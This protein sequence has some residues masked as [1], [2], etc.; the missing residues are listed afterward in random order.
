VLTVAHEEADR[1]DERDVER[2]TSLARSSAAAVANAIDF[3]RER[4]ISRALTLGFVPEPLPEL[5]GYEAGLQ[6]VPAFN[7]PAGGDVYGAWRLPGGEVAMLVGDVAG[8]GVETAALSSM[9]RFF[10][11]A[12]S[13][14]STSPAAV[15]AE[16]NA[17]LA[18][19]MPSDSFV[20]VFLALLEPGRLR[21]ASAGHLPPLLIRHDSADALGATAVPLGVD[22]Q[23]DAREVTL[24]LN[25]GDLVFAYT[26]GLMEA[27]RGGAV[28]GLDRL[29]DFVVKM[30]RV[31]GPAELV[32][33]VHREVAGWADGLADDVVALA[34]RRRA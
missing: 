17:M 26:D 24:E 34:L 32:H 6:Y 25:E 2:V 13:W 21:Y 7:E 27:R 9:V 19:R 33:R 11:E 5:P 22:A 3:E 8:K 1:F 12:R 23:L 20:T 4:R 29:S 15:L 14:G 31:L 10:I 30:G 28:Y 16:T 18:G